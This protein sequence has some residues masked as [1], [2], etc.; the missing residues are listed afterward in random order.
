[1]KSMTDEDVK[2]AIQKLGE[3]NLDDVQTVEDALKRVERLK[4]LR[5]LC[6]GEANL[7]EVEYDEICSLLGEYQTVLLGIKLR[8]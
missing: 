5:A 2:I 1:M 3:E 6:Y 8:S 4:Y 7:T